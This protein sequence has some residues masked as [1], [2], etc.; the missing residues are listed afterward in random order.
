LFDGLIMKCLCA[1]F[2]PCFLMAFLHSRSFHCLFLAISPFWLWPLCHTGLAWWVKIFWWLDA[3]SKAFK[4]TRKLDVIKLAVES[5]FRLQKMSDCTMDYLALSQRKEEVTGSLHAS[6]LGAPVTFESFVSTNLKGCWGAIHRDNH[7]C[8]RHVPL[9]EKKWQYAY[10]VL[11]RSLKEG[12]MFV[13][14]WL[15]YFLF[16]GNRKQHVS[17]A[18]DMPAALEEVVGN[19]VLYKVCA[20]VI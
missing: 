19:E 12:A 9:N 8:H 11:K 15:R 18:T 4:K 3:I 1:S 14:S 10:R 20:E 6:T 2:R 5:S 7:R 17:L 16:I 13:T